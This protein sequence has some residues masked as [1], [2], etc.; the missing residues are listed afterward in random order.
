[1]RASSLSNAKIIDLLNGYFVP[2]Y[3]RNQDFDEN[4]SAPSQQKKEKYRIYRDAL[5][6]GLPA[7]SVCAY[8]LTPDAK[9]VDVAPLNQSDATDPKKLAAKMERLIADQKIVKGQPLVKPVPQSAVPKCDRDSIALHLTARYLEKREA[10]LLQPVDVTSVLGT[11]GAGNWGNLPSEDWIVL[12][13]EDWSKLLPSG[14]VGVGTTWIPDADVVE[15]ILK[16]FFPPTEN[17]NF[18]KNTVAEL[19]IRGRV[20]SVQEGIVQSRIDGRMKMK[21]PFYHQDDNNVV[22]ASLVGWLE[23]AVDRQT[24]RSFQLVTDSATYGQPG[25]NPQSFGVALR[26]VR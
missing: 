14:E 12:G 3:L 21:H 2:V 7:G 19:E 16:R 22:Q 6:A 11:K 15:R 25:G 5:A 23:F 10:G 9:P 20:E 13:K 18:E 24:I 1:M 26:S 4:G 17:T 8:L